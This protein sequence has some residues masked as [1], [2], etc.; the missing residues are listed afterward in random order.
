MSIRTIESIV[1]IAEDRRLILQLPSD[2]VPGRHRIVTVVDE[3]PVL[4]ECDSSPSAQDWQFP[5]L[6]EAQ[7][8]PDMPVTRD[9]MYGDDGR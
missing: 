7:W 8:P 1:D 9:A 4:V 3:S 2:I 6:P 5:V